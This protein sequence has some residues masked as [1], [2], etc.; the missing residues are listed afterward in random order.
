[1]NNEP[2][3]IYTRRFWLDTTERVVRTT[4]Q[5]ALAVFGVPAL[6]GALDV[7]SID[8]TLDGWQGKVAVV[9]AAAVLTLL[10]CLAGRRTGDRSTASLTSGTGAVVTY[11]A[12]PSAR[13]PYGPGVR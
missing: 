13:S 2:Q 1:M 8:D 11:P 10:T 6:G 12:P 9:A 4:A 5:V 3:S 7:P